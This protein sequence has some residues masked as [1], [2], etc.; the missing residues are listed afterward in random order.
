MYSTLYSIHTGKRDRETKRTRFC[1][2]VFV[3]VWQTNRLRFVNARERAIRV[4][5]ETAA[6][7]HIFR[8]CSRAYGRPG[9][10]EHIHVHLRGHIHDKLVFSIDSIHR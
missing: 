3:S 6:A 10:A 8:N 1:A 9:R 7:V 4:E 2:R 5:V